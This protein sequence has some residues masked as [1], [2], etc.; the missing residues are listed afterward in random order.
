MFSQ[1]GRTVLLNKWHG[2]MQKE[3]I[4][5]ARPDAQKNFR[6]FFLLGRRPGFSD[7]E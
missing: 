6:S 1:T 5:N 2:N 3:I 7:P 4:Q